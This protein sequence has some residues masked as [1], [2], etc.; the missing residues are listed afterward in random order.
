MS[1]YYFCYRFDLSG[2]ALEPVVAEPVSIELITGDSLKQK[3]DTID[4][5]ASTST[6]KVKN[7]VS[8]PASDIPGINIF[9]VCFA[10]V[11]VIAYAI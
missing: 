7:S 6:Q 2:S 3:A 1:L 11:A 4:H 9:V 10:L 8:I 5:H